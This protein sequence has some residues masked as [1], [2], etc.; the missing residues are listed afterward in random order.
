MLHLMKEKF[1]FDW[2]RNKSLDT[3]TEIDFGI[4]W[5]KRR[6]NI[7]NSRAGKDNPD[8]HN[9]ITFGEE[10]GSEEHIC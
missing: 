6:E 4:W 7:S 10:C 8:G 2:S 1:V 5:H 9:H 3:A